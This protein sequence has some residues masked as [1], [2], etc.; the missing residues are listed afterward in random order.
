MDTA[1]ASGFPPNFEASAVRSVE[2]CE[3]EFS[4]PH[5]LASPDTAMAVITAIEGPS[6]R[7]VGAAMVVD[8]SGKSYGNLS[9]VCIERDV[10]LHA[11]NALGDGKGRKLRY[12]RNSPFI[13]VTPPCGGSL[14]IEIFPY[15]DR[16][17]LAAAA[18]DL[19]Q[20]K[21][22]CIWLSADGIVS[23]RPVVQPALTLSI[24]PQ[25]RFLVFGKGP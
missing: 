18:N 25:L 20:R 24:I 23:R 6:Y 16:D 21:A 14:D 13:D 19:S 17:V 7:P 2:I 10:A 15:P 8:G 11:L 22:A 1:V 9:S 5:A 3:G 4:V 12:G